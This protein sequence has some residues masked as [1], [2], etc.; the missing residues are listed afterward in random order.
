MRKNPI[1]F[2][3][4]VFVSTYTSCQTNNTVSVRKKISLTDSLKYYNY[5]EKANSVPIFSLKRQFYLD[6]ALAIVPWNAQLWQQKAMPLFKQKKYEIGMPYI[7]MAVIHDKKNQWL[8]YRAFIK[9]I[10]QKSYREA[11]KDF[12]LAI[13]KK[14]NSYVMDHT[15]EFYKGLCYLQLN[16]LDSAEY[17]ITK[18][19]TEERAAKGEDWVHYLHVFYKGIIE[20]E[21]EDYKN[22]IETF[23]MCLNKFPQLPDA[24]YYKANCLYR[25]QNLKDALELLVQA[26]EYMKQGYHI[27]EDNA[28]YEPYPYQV[29]QWYLDTYITTL[30]EKIEKK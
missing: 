29:N 6:S 30:K 12:D 5:L 10:F 9:C 17:F 16:K 7:D 19:I 25:Q 14:G 15:Y 18:C 3:L 2:F 28:I 11:L 8:E 24:M 21:K 20:F 1:M 13:G 26:K 27:N 23:N 22:A 4:L